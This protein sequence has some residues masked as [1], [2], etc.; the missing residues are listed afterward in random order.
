MGVFIPYPFSAL[1]DRIQWIKATS[2]Y[3]AVGLIPLSVNKNPGLLLKEST[4]YLLIDT[5]RKAF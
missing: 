2:L 3:V 4:A 1:G 5:K